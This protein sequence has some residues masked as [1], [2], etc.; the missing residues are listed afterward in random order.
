ML[1]TIIAA[2]IPTI[3]RLVEGLINKP[4]SGPQKADTAFAMVLTAFQELIKNGVISEKTIS[5]DGIRYAI[6]TAVQA[7]KQ[8]GE[9]G[10]VA[11]PFAGKKVILEGIIREV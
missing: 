9:L 6:E 8:N 11:A 7:L 1:P 2:S 3:V 5:D 10:G 4:K